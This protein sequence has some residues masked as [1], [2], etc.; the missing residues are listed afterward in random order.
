MENIEKFVNFLKDRD[1]HHLIITAKNRYDIVFVKF[2]R[3]ESFDFIYGASQSKLLDAPKDGDGLPLPNGEDL[4]WQGF[5]HFP[6]LSLC[7]P[8]NLVYSAIGYNP[9]FSKYGIREMLM[10]DVNREYT[11]TVD[12]ILLSMMKRDGPFEGCEDEKVP[13]VTPDAEDQA[14]R[15]AYSAYMDGQD[16]I[17]YELPRAFW[18]LEKYNVI[19]FIEGNLSF[20]DE[21]IDEYYKNNKKHLE[22]G[23]LVTRLA[24]SELRRMNATPGSHSICREMAKSITTQKMVLLDIVKNGVPLTVKYK[25]DSLKR[26]LMSMH[27]FIWRHYMDAASRSSYVK[28]YDD[29]SDVATSEVM[30]IRYG[31][32]T[33]WQREK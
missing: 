30:A 18:S 25:A 4:D 28:T 33:L 17:H 14:K 8:G 6:T 21:R 27:P 19:G 7:R 2:K 3:S 32:K 20:I 16:V 22:R 11:K 1:A 5:F 31:K 15:I 26:G 13:E 24:N 9:D 23:L 12:N 10:E 29:R